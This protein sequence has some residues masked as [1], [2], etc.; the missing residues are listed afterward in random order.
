MKL[1]AQAKQMAEKTKT[2]GKERLR[3]AGTYS[4]GKEGPSGSAYYVTQSEN[5]E[6]TERTR[7]LVP[8]RSNLFFSKPKAETAA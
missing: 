4:I 5:G 7:V 8:D 3:G 1:A 2:S 6:V